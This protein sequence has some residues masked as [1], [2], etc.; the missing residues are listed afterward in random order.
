M[1]ER[2]PDPIIDYVLFWL[3]HGAKQITE[4]PRRGVHHW[5]ARNIS[6][7]YTGWEYP[8]SKVYFEPRTL[9]ERLLQGRVHEVMCEALEWALNEAEAK[10][11]KNWS[12]WDGI[13]LAQAYRIAHMVV[14]VDPLR[15]PALKVRLNKICCKVGK[16]LKELVDI[17]FMVLIGPETGI[18]F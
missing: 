4:D 12:A 14:Q 16:T 18:S 5:T 1:G 17:K 15:A 8:M 9:K 2:D 7:G 3:E 11:P 13:Y 10:T 6:G